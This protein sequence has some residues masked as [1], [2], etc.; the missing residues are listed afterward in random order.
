MLTKSIVGRLYT[1]QLDETK[2][3]LI[4]ELPSHYD[5]VTAIRRPPVAG[6][7]TVGLPG[8]GLRPVITPAGNREV[9]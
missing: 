3:R 2:Y 9:S 6:G 8:A 1:R 5:L 7:A 4:Q